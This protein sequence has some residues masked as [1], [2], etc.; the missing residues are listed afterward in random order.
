VIAASKGYFQAIGLV[1]GFMAASVI[2]FSAYQGWGKALPPLMVSTLRVALV[3]CGG[4]LLMQEADPRLDG[5]YALIA[6]ATVLGALI[7]GAIFVL[8][9]PV[10][11]QKPVSG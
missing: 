7:L 2:L 6:G 3:L 10:Q 5:L 8:R 11:S 9:P 4:W 1:Y